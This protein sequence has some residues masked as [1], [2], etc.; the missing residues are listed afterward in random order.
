M[1]GTGFSISG[2]TYR[3]GYRLT[4]AKCSVCGKQFMRSPEWVYKNGYKKYQCSYKC[5][6]VLDRKE[7]DKY[8]KA[9]DKTLASLE[10]SS[11]KPPET[12]A[13][14]QEEERLKRTLPE[15]RLKVA[16]NRARICQGWVDEYRQ[17][18]HAFYKGEYKH[19]YNMKQSNVWAR[20]LRDA[21][22]EIASIEKE[23]EA[24][25]C[26]DPEAMG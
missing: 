11:K 3:Y 24:R 26:T 6:R 19:R 10:R 20:K 4:E 18:A 23:M 12:K 5:Y 16:Q 13:R 21:Q 25:K 22:E 7:R 2:S 17:R 8:S 9:L 15:Y 1:S 14:H